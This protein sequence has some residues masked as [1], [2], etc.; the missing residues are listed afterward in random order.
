MGE[1]TAKMV[2]LLLFILW[3]QCLVH[4]MRVYKCPLTYALFISKCATHLLPILRK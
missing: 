1:P 2:H 3:P 4:A